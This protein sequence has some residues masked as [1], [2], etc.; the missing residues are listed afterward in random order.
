MNL[1]LRLIFLFLRF[2]CRKSQK[3][4][5]SQ[6]HHI[7]FW[8]TPIDCDMNGHLTNSRYFS[9]MDLARLDFFIYAQ[10]YDKD[11]A[12]QRI[13]P[14]L[15]GIEISFIEEIFPFSSVEV[16]TKILGLDEKYCYIEHL[17]YVDKRLKA[18]ARARGV[19]VTHRKKRIPIQ[20][21]EQHISQK[22]LKN[23]SLEK[24]KEYLHLK[25]EDLNSQ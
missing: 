16:Q 7:R 19:F 22:L 18:H 2:L 10:G 8:V 3:C 21:L 11:S 4:S 12:K 25:K 20:E 14:L 15:Q 13:F 5:F 1:W 24:W 6:T 17:F 23:K 9:F